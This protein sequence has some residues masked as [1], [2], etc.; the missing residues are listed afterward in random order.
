MASVVSLGCSHNVK[1][2]E[3][4]YPVIKLSNYLNF[5][6]AFLLAGLW[7]FYY[8]WRNKHDLSNRWNISKYFKN[9]DNFICLNCVY[10]HF[11]NFFNEETISEWL[12]EKQNN[13]EAFRE[14]LLRM[15]ISGGLI[16]YEGQKFSY[17]KMIN[18]FKIEMPPTF[19][20]LQKNRIK[21]NPYLE[22]EGNQ[23]VIMNYL[24]KRYM[25]FRSI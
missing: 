16:P 10:F 18:V 25:S 8:S 17:Y 5:V 2:Y 15:L 1:K 20:F 12:S 13:L 24:K 23:I 22:N 9:F 7:F 14:D 21:L 19:V 3:T 4:I 6:V 11:S